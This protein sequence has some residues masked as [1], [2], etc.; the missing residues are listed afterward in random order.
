[1]RSEILKAK[2]Q[3]I[4]K[5]K[6]VGTNELGQ[7]VFFDAHKKNGGDGSAPTPM[8]VML[9]TLAGCSAMDVIA[10]LRKKRKDI[11]N[12]EILLEAE[13]A[14]EHPK[15]FAKVMM[16]YQLRSS[17]TNFAEFSDAVRLSQE[18]YCSISAMFK[19]SGCIV[20]YKVNLSE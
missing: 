3:L 5:M 9:Q 13:R 15:V 10:I 12:F 17:D 2:L 1:M 16:I 4:D 8:E 19:R 18:K 11:G 14:S 6:F 7:S 20:E